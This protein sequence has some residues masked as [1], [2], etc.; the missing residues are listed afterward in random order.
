MSKIVTPKQD[1]TI[2]GRTPTV[3]EYVQ[4]YLTKMRAPLKARTMFGQAGRAVI[5]SNGEGII[6]APDGTPIRVVENPEGGNQIEHGD[7]L[8][9]VVRPRVVNLTPHT[10]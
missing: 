8:H 3:D 2:N 1:A 10:S 7:H 9:A 4:S 6:Y 5:H